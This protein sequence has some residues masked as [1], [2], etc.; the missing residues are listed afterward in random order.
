MLCF[1]FAIFSLWQQLK[2]MADKD[3]KHISKLLTFW[4]LNNPFFSKQQILFLCLMYWEERKSNYAAVMLAGLRY[5]STNVISSLYLT[6]FKC[7]HY[8]KASFEYILI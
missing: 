2:L 6:Y 1:F 8:Q 3:L 7:I 4:L 5:S